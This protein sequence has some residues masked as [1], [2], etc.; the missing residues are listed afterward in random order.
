MFLYSGSKLEKDLNDLKSEVKKSDYEKTIEPFQSRI[1]EL[2]RE[3]FTLRQNMSAIISASELLI[4]SIEKD[5]IKVVITLTESK[6]YYC[7]GNKPEFEKPNFQ[8]VEIPIKKDLLECYYRDIVY[9]IN[10]YKV[11]D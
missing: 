10:K 3:L 5:Y 9:Y 8:T 6:A 7:Y 11:G 4:K 2:E 1:I